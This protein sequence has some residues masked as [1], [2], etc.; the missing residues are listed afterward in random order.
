MKTRICNTIEEAQPYLKMCLVSTGAG[1]LLN[2]QT[3][4]NSSMHT[5][6][7]ETGPFSSAFSNTNDTSLEFDKN[8]ICPRCNYIVVNPVEC[9]SCQYIICWKCAQSFNMKCQDETCGERFTSSPGKIHKLYKEMLYQM[10]FRCPNQAQGCSKV[11]KY[12]MLD[13]HLQKS[14]EAKQQLCPNRCSKTKKYSPVELQ[15]H[16]DEECPKECVPCPSCKQIKY[17]AEIQEHLES[18][19][20]KVQ[21]KCPHCQQADF[22]ISFRN[23]KHECP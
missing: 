4:S 20:D 23:G 3:I 12:D 21:V 13:L 22:R 1:S 17:R 15:R 11:L 16:L 9:Q 7:N 14:C 6:G 10:E 19:C 5:I 8:L 18:Q 2:T